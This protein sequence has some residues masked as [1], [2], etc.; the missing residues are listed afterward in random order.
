M[1]HNIG[2]LEGDVYS[3]IIET[4]FLDKIGKVSHTKSTA[5]GIIMFLLFV[6]IT[7]IIYWKC[8]CCRDR[9]E[10]CC[11]L[12]MPD[13]LHVW[14]EKRALAKL[15]DAGERAIRLKELDPEEANNPVENPGN[16]MN[17]PGNPAGAAQY[18][19]VYESEGGKPREHAAPSAM[20]LSGS[21]TS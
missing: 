17:N 16:P 20:P 11:F 6:L 7:S 1:R 5:F 10:S 18:S 3:D 9:V 12:C 2:N 13:C 8:A 14:R 21:T 4:V 15:R 19:G